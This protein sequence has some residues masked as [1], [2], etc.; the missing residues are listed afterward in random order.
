MSGDLI[1][2]E[3]LHEVYRHARREFPRECCGWLAGARDDVRISKIRPC[4]N[5]Q[6]RPEAQC[7]SENELHGVVD[8]TAETAYVIGGAELLELV[9]ALDGP[10]PPRIFYHSHPNGRAYFSDTDRKVAMD[11]WDE[12]PNY[13]MAQLVVG[14]DQERVVEAKLFSW[15]ESAQEFVGVAVYTGAEI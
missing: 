7:S 8:R 2:E 10:E 12:G 9:R 13:P 11:P 5:V 6:G 14:I 3:L 15:D 4:R 1:P